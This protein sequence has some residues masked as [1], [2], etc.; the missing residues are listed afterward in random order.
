MKKQIEEVREEVEEVK[1]KN[2]DSHELIVE[3]FDRATKRDRFHTTVLLIIILFLLAIIAYD[4]Y[5]D[6]NTGCTETTEETT[7][8]QSGCGCNNF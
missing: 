4:S 8:E 6:A 2:I 5:Q 7:T 1:K 3:T